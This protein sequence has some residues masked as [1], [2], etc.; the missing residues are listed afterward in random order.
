MVQWLG[1]HGLKASGEVLP[2][3][4]WDAECLAR[5]VQDRAPSLVVAG[6]YGHSRSREW[7]LGG[8]TLDYLLNPDRPMFL[9]H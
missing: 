2:L 6:A 4:G 8:V 7:V 5:L 3:K 9:A 1:R